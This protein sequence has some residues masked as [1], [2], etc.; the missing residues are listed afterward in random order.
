MPQSTRATCSAMRFPRKVISGPTGTTA[1]R[2]NA[3]AKASSG[4]RLKRNLFR[5]AP[6]GMKSSL[7]SIL[8]TS[9]RMCGMPFSGRSERGGWGGGRRRGAGG[10]RGGGGARGGGGG[11]GGGGRGGWWGGGG[12][13]GRGGGG[14]AARPGRRRRGAAGGWGGRGGGGGGGQLL[15]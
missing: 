15:R 6:S 12:G 11:G 10:G 1:K 9:A 5:E 8:R 13:G 14:A 4:A 7:K 3:G 2:Q